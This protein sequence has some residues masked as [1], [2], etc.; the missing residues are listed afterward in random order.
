MSGFF[1]RRWTQ[2]RVSTGVT[3]IAFVDA[4]FA[5]GNYDL[6]AV[7][8]DQ[9]G[10]NSE[11][12]LVSITVA[13]PHA[14]PQVAITAP[15]DG[16][17]LTNADLAVSITQLGGSAPAS[18]EVTIDG[19]TAAAAP[20]TGDPLVIT[21]PSASL[22]DGARTLVANCTDAAANT[23]PSNAVRVII[24]ST[25]PAD[26]V[27]A[28]EDVGVAG[29]LDFDVTPS[30]VILAAA[31][32]SSQAGLQHP[33]SVLVHPGTENVRSWVVRLSVTP[34]GQPVRIY[35]TTLI[36]GG[37]PTR[38][39]FDAVD[40]GAV[41][42]PIDF[43]VTVT[44]TL[45]RTSAADTATLVIDRTPPA[46]TLN[47][48][49]PAQG[50]LTRDDDRDLSTIDIVDIDFTVS[51]TGGATV[52][53]SIE[54]A[55][56]G[57]TPQTLPA[58][59]S[60]TFARVAFE[61]GSYAATFAVT[62]TS[63]NVTTFVYAFTVRALQA[64]VTIAAPVA[65]RLNQS[66]DTDAATPGAQVLITITATG[67][68]PSSPV[69]LC[70]TVPVNGASTP[71][72]FGRN[73]AADA[74]DRGVI[75][76]S[77]TLNGILQSSSKQIVALLAEGSQVLHAEAHELDGDPY[78]ASD[79]S[80]RFVDSVPPIVAAASFTQN[81]AGNDSGALIRLN[82]TEGTPNG[83]TGLTV[84]LAVQV[85]GLDTICPTSTTDTATPC[86]LNV[87]SGGN[88]VASAAATATGL[89]PLTL[90]LPNGSYTLTFDARDAS[91]NVN[92]AATDLIGSVTV[93]V[94]AQVDSA[95][96][97]APRLNPY[98]SAAGTVSG[99]ELILDPSYA[100]VV[101]VSDTSGGGTVTLERYTAPSGGTAVAS[102]QAVLNNG[103][104]SNSFTGFH[105]VQGFNYIQANYTDRAGNA[106][107][108]GRIVYAADFIGPNLSLTVTN[109]SGGG[110]SCNDTTPCLADTLPR[111]Q[112]DERVLLDRT[113]STAGCGGTSC[114]T[115]G[116][117]L[118]YSLASCVNSAPSLET[119]SGTIQLESRVVTGGAPTAFAPVFNGVFT[120]TET[121]GA[122]IPTDPQFE[123]GVVRE[124]RLTTKD[125][126]GNAST[127]PSVFLELDFSGVAVSVQRLDAST[128]PTGDLLATGRYFGIKEDT[129]TSDSLFTTNFRANLTPFGDATPTS[130]S[131]IVNSTAGTQTYTGVAQSATAYDFIGVSLARATDP[132]APLANAIDV[133]VMCGCH[134]LRPTLV[135]RHHR[136]HRRADLSVR[137]VHA[138]GARRAAVRW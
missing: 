99:S 43:S 108:T 36:N 55:P 90:A 37:E 87:R 53:L 127:S 88:I 1:S 133:E 85:N 20:W 79:F 105:L 134:R 96:L 106:T 91:G 119:C 100:I 48:P 49:A 130:V 89:I 117:N 31:D 7:Y 57:F 9:L 65:T 66:Y 63:G 111:G 107:S 60:V 135:H 54:P 25:A 59:A 92:G 35:A 136:R 80:T 3:A 47:T 72:K 124:L 138:A 109:G 13:A 42:G 23:L 94:D 126:N 132:A 14:G 18:C 58:A 69:D 5:Y 51:T 30:Y 45:G 118:V 103:Q 81:N 50:L 8:T 62:D 83:N 131:L 40:F 82:R 93:Q 73:G 39:T 11:S 15:R 70:S 120:K 38:V 102:A 86:V 27:L 101:S 10:N 71:C 76:A 4:S 64:T 34:P 41:D 95:S 112:T 21:V 115:A 28:S 128:A 75:I 78:V 24:D 22:T 125:S 44:D 84:V 2:Q 16:D 33:V 74:T 123:P 26:P 67:I 113:G 6:V 121:S 19:I 17:T 98:T 56:S 114:S 104:T 61:S 122:S 46:I 29:R 12:P 77:D 129:V 68:N 52:A 110:L 116:T 97:D 32:T 137:P